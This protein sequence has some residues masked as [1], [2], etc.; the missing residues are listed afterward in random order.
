[1][2]S[3]D[4]TNE[5]TDISEGDAWDPKYESQGKGFSIVVG[6]TSKGIELLKQLH[7]NILLTL[8]PINLD[9]ALSMH[10]HML[11][12]KKRGSFIRISWRRKLR[13]PFPDYGYKV[14]DIK[15]M[16]YIVELVISGTFLICGT[17]IF[18]NIIEHI[19]IK[20]LGPM[21]NYLRI[22][23]KRISKPSKRKGLQDIKIEISPQIQSLQR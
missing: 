16:R 21:F 20:F 1:M 8:E 12:F 5:F 14:I 3:I 11:D 17:Q 22:N 13:L 9:D 2:L 15:F 18:R 19:S 10:G 6:R 23:W 7:S 4:F